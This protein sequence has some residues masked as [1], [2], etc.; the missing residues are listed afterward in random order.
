LRRQPPDVIF[1][2]DGGESNSARSSATN[3]MLHLYDGV[4]VALDDAKVIAVS[5]GW[6]K[7]AAQ[8]EEELKMHPA[9]RDRLLKII[10]FT[11]TH[12]AETSGLLSVL[13][14]ELPNEAKIEMIRISRDRGRGQRVFYRWR[15]RRGCTSKIPSRAQGDFAKATSIT[16]LP[17][18]F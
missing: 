12:S 10:Q 9:I 8:L 14:G 5:F 6:E 3:L 11:E 4:G 18:D 13:T 1:L 7:S 16:S 15:L 2:F 17:G